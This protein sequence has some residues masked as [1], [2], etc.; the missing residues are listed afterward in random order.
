L[1]RTN[2]I[3]VTAFFGDFGVHVALGAFS[4]RAAGLGASPGTIGLVGGVIDLAYTIVA[5]SLP[6]FTDAAS[7]A[8]VVRWA[9]GA[10]AA[11]GLGALLAESLGGFVGALTLLRAGSA[12]FWPTLQAR[13]SDGHRHELGRAVSAFSLSWCCGKTLGYGV[14][15]ACLGSFGPRPAYAITFAAAVAIMLLVPK[16]RA[17]ADDG[18]DGADVA[19]AV[20]RRR[21]VAAWIGAFLACAAF[22]VLQ[23]QNAPLMA[24]KAHSGGF[25]N[26]MLAV[27]VA[28]NVLVF[29]HLR[30]RPQLA[31]AAC[32]LVA[33]LALLVAGTAVLFLTSGRAGLLG[34][35]AALG[36]GMGLA[37]TQSLF[38]SLRL[39]LRKS[40][41]AGIHE[42]FIG[43]ANAT[44]A[45]LAGL[46]TEAYGTANGALLFSF[47]LL[48]AGGTTVLLCLRRAGAAR[49]PEA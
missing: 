47:S 37:Y 45:P 43:I 27:L 7:R 9:A 39:P 5:L 3:F 46:A 20:R 21:V 30:R 44:V 24:T 10:M 1:I 23:N 18:A 38:L 35:A 36:V 33:S 17:R 31:G 26:L 13:L 40:V 15:A 16:D 32:A 6:R 48:V 49:A 28:F 42:A 34:G 22:V 11:G 25:G 4:Y 14:N 2:R 29:D 8:V 41:G 12:V 19:G